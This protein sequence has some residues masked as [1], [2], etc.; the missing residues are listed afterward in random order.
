MYIPCS[1]NQKDWKHFMNFI[2]DG[3]GQGK[4]LHKILLF[5]IKG[6]KWDKFYIDFVEPFL[7]VTLKRIWM[8]NAFPK[9]IPYLS[10]LWK[11]GKESSFCIFLVWQW[12]FIAGRIMHIPISGTIY[13]LNSS[14]L[15]RTSENSVY[16][17]DTFQGVKHDFDAIIVYISL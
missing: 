9:V 4:S 7:K 8:W 17:I 13:E 12:N 10:C 3:D 2:I 16:T 1:V 14:K 11:L 6:Y 5:K 15:F